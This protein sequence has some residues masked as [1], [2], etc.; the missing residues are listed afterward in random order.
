MRGSPPELSCRTKDC[1]GRGAH[2]TDR[3]WGV[4]V[5][6]ISDRSQVTCRSAVFCVDARLHGVRG[7]TGAYTARGGGREVVSAGV[8]R[9][10]VCPVDILVPGKPLIWIIGEVTDFELATV[11]GTR[12]S[13]SE[14]GCTSLVSRETFR[15]R[16]SECRNRAGPKHSELRSGVCVSE[17][18]RAR[19]RVRD[20][21]HGPAS[22]P[23]AAEGWP[24]GRVV[25]GFPTMRGEGRAAFAFRRKAIRSRVART[26][27]PARS[28][29]HPAK[30]PR[31][32]ISPEHVR[33]P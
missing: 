2:R 31:V 5:R 24:A 27:P 30:L 7:S 32:E 29:G 10:A 6:S 3:R 11:S 21:R 17:K 14:A 15:Q 26:P 25:G 13:R 9:A 33:P 18:I 28:T 16:L 12:S 4:D 8:R 23:R 19:C 20:V 22:G 1:G